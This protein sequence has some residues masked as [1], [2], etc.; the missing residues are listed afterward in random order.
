[1]V[2]GPGRER[3]GSRVLMLSAQREGER[4]ETVPRA[5]GRGRGK[6]LRE[7]REESAVWKP[8]CGRTGPH[9]VARA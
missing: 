7:L 5:A 2:G 3:P 8:R 1:M 9:S 6:H 4:E